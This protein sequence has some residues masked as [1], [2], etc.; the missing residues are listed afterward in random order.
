MVLEQGNGWFLVSSHGCPA[1]EGFERPNKGRQISL[2][3]QV[4]MSLEAEMEKVKQLISQ[5]MGSDLR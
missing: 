5:R 3:K 4:S 1:G 2:K